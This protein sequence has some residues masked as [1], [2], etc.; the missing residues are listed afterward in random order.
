VNPDNGQP[1]DLKKYMARATVVSLK[2]DI[3]VITVR[4]NDGSSHPFSNFM[5]PEASRDRW[6]HIENH[7]ELLHCDGV[8]LCYF[9]GTL[10]PYSEEMYIVSLEPNLATGELKFVDDEFLIKTAE[11]SFRLVRSGDDVTAVLE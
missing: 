1:F 8:A 3:M 11:L 9:S 2:P 6:S 7:R 5:V 4:E 10:M